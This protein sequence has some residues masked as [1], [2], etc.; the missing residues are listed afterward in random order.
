MNKSWVLL[1][2]FTSL[3]CRAGFSQSSITILSGKDFEQGSDRERVELTYESLNIYKYGDSFFWIDVTSPFNKKSSNRETNMYGE[4]APRLSVAKILDWKLEGFVSDV[5]LSTGFEF[6]NSSFGQT[7]TSLYGIGVDL[8]IPGFKFF[9]YNL[10]VRDNIDK[11]GTSLQSTFVYNL[12][13]QIADQSFALNAYIDIV[14]SDEGEGSNLTEA[15]INTAQQ[16]HYYVIADMFSI[17]LEYQYWNRKFGIQGGF[18]ENNLKVF[19]Q[20][21]F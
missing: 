5:L 9:S 21:V 16:L 13:F 19:A 15:H 11:Q 8:K 17:G 4:W 2:W 18:V 3:A 14:H 20:W 1:L 12:P 6:G 10:Y 7:R